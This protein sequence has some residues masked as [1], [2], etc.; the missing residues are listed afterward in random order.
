MTQL[1]LS[2]F[3]GI[4]LLDK[5]FE[6]EGFTVV[7]SRDWIMG[8]DVRNTHFPPDRFDGVIG[9]PPCQSFTQLVHMIRHNGHKPKFG[10]L[11]PDF[12]RVVAETEPQW[13]LM[14]EVPAAPRPQVDGYK[15][16]EFE[17]N[18]RQCFDDDG[19]PAKQNR[20]RAI[21][22]GY[23]GERRVLMVE[24]AALYNQEWEYAV[25]GD[26]RT[27]P[28]AM[29]AGKKPKRGHSRT[30]SLNRGAAL[31]SIDEMLTGQGM[32]PGFVNRQPFKSSALRQMIGNGV[33]LPMGRAIAKAVMEATAALTSEVAKH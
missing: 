9:G 16:H 11:I 8:G 15:T 29:L 25:C 7:Q 32:S 6:L 4:G 17:L 26:S 2:L 14:E 10:N 24:T 5:A 30:S 23:R 18:N 12:E 20:V 27:R 28:V 1:V 19:K 33:P 31:K 13:F 21:T 3:P 22:F